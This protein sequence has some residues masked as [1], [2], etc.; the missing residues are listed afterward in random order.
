MTV[1]GLH[2]GN[3]EMAELR[4]ELDGVNRELAQLR[5]ELRAATG[6]GTNGTPQYPSRPRPTLYDLEDWIVNFMQRTLERRASNTKRWCAQW[7]KHPEV[8]SRFWA[9]Y[10]AYLQIEDEG[11]AIQ[12]SIWY[13][14]HLDRHLETIT[15]ADGPFAACS[16]DRHTPHRGLVVARNENAAAD[17]GPRP[18]LTTH[19]PQSTTPQPRR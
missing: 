19:F 1:R 18:R 8:I 14:D 5:Q 2:E 16:I 13:V 3:R 11:D 12:M 9:L 7:H 4:R 10:H 6:N 17:W 15:S